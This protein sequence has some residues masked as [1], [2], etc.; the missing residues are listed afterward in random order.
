MKVFIVRISYADGMLGTVE[1]LA[2]TVQQAIDKVDIGK[3]DYISFCY[4]KA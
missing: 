1:V 3:N 2:N 4:E